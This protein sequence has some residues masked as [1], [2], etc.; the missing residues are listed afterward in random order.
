MVIALALGDR[1]A[2]VALSA[3]KALYGHPSASR[4]RS[5]PSAA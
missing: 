1:P 2:E 4:A 5:R 3:M